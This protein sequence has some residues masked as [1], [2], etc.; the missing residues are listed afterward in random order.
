MKKKAKRYQEGG[1]LRDRFG[2]PVRS[3]SGE[4]VRT[5][6]PERS[7]DEQST[8]DMT[9]SSDYT[10]RRRKSPERSTSDMDSDS[11]YMPSGRT[12]SIGY[13]NDEE[14]SERKITDY[15]RTSP[16]EDSVTETVKEEVKPKPKP[17]P[18]PKTK[19]KELSGMFGDIDSDALNRRRLEG[20]KKEDSPYGKSERLKAMA[21]TFSADRAF[22][23]TAAST[24]YG[25]SKMGMKSG[26][27]VSSASSRADGIAQ[28]G[29]TKGRIC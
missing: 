3:G 18:K 10:G 7:Y 4:A 20:L 17:K 26:G 19:K 21:G 11:S 6:Y 1:V 29:K 12:P 25:R 24:P 16:K 2:N 15:I 28:R 8:A 14:S 13:G 22:K 27:K 9:E 23:S 5:R